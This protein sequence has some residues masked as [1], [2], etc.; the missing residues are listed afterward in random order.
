[1]ITAEWA[2]QWRRARTVVTLGALVV[3]SVL[4]AGL[5]AATG[6]ATVDRVGDVPLLVVPRGSGLSVGLIALSSTMK[7]FLPLAVALF[8]G[9]AVAG[10]ARW[11]TMRSTLVQPVSRSRY[12]ASKLAVAFV[13]SLAAVAVLA[14][15]S[16]V[17]GVVAFGWHP[18]SVVDGSAAPA[19]ATTYEP[20][21]ALGRLATGTAY[22]AAGMASIFAVAF[23]ASTLTR[24]PFVAVAAGVGTT[25]VSRVFNGDYLPGV[26]TVSRYMPNN[27]IDLWQ[28]LFTRPQDTS[29]MGRFLVVQLVYVVVFLAVGWA[30][31]LRR[32]VLS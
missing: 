5:I 32:D 12:L 11:G 26:A 17:A 25:I 20:A 1:M 10:S 22:I 31:F 4:L 27:D 21:A 28:H 13:L 3:F 24:R 6:S 7:F 8:A 16:V 23:C 19:A 15:S 9:E 14:I 18:L 2:V 30:A 29:G